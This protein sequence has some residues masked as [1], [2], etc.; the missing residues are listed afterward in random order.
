MNRL[1]RCLNLNEIRTLAKRR[2]PRIAFD[3]IDGGVEDEHG[4]EWN[5]QAFRQNFLVPRYC[6]DVSHR[7]Q[8]VELFGH[9]Y[10]SPI[11]ICPM[12]AGS[13]AAPGADI[14]LAKAAARFNV[15]YIMSSASNA[16]MEQAAEV[17]PDNTWFQLY[18]AKSQHITNDLL[19]RA[20]RSGIKVIVVTVD[21]PLNSRRERNVRNGF[22]R[23]SKINLSSALEA[24]LHPSW[25]VSYL[26]HNDALR[27]G[28]Y[29]PYLSQDK[30][31]PNSSELYARETPNPRQSWTWLK[32]L[33]EQW[34]HKLVIKGLLD[35]HDA[36]QAGEMGVDGIMV[37]NHGARQLDRAPAPVQVMEAM[38]EAAGSHVTIMTDSGIRRGSDVV[39]N[40]CLGAQ[41]SFIGRPAL[42]GVAAGKQ[43]GI[44][45]VLSLL[46]NEIDLVLGQIGIAKFEQLDHSSLFRP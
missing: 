19:A 26:Y 42:F 6:V 40:K 4:V 46:K 15:P 13:L 33:R 1:D 28:N 35:P 16:S 9:R 25:I 23:P 34:S 20:D 11:G 30:S 32:S 31:I 5:A 44:D 7:D 43:R 24:L 8:S 45:R 21:V 39:I 41:M 27:L 12:G 17:A 18:A 2:L 37:S 3:F 36:R 14:M 38:K 10:S 22:V 29:E